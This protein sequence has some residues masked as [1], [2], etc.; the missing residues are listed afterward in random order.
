[1]VLPEPD[2]ERNRTSVLSAQPSLVTINMN[3]PDH[4]TWFGES[5]S[6]IWTPKPV[7]PYRDGSMHRRS[8]LAHRTTALPRFAVR[9]PCNLPEAQPCRLMYIMSECNSTIHDE[10]EVSAHER[11]M[12]LMRRG[13]HDNN[14]SDPYINTLHSPQT[15]YLAREG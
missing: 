12:Y 14:L 8:K 11:V 10:H 5:Q 3:W 4:I 2:C 1:M 15:T 13:T 6:F 7:V 9:L